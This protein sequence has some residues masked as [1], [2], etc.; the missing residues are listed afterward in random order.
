ME[1]VGERRPE[2][3]SRELLE[4]DHQ[5]PRRTAAEPLRASCADAKPVASRAISAF[6][7]GTEAV[8]DD[9][10]IGGVGQ[11]QTQ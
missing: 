1:H 4:H 2:R 5:G 11:W 10:D 8:M 6:R 7:E 9:R 3:P